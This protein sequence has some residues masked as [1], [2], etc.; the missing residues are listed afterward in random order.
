MTIKVFVDWQNGEILTEEEYEKRVKKM[1]ENLR[2]R[3]YDFSEFLEE[4]YSHREL[5]DADEKQRAKIM[6][7]WADQCLEDAYCEQDYEGVEL[8]V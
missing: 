6:E 4:K 8:E 2:T 5:W 7:Y 3:D 1:A